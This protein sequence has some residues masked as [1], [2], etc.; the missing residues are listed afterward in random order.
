MYDK[1]HS[2]LELTSN[3]SKVEAQGPLVGVVETV[4]MYKGCNYYRYINVY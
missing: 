4:S 2:I 1:Y 3:T